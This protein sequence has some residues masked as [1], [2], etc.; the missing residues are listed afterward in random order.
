[1]IHE[2][3]NTHCGHYYDII[4]DPVAGQWFTYNDKVR[5]AS[6]YIYMCVYPEIKRIE[7]LRR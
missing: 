1:M 4:K 3:Q 6:L 5:I 7:L 2:G